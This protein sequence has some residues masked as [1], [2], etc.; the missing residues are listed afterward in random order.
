MLNCEEFINKYYPNANNA[1]IMDA[2]RFLNRVD[3][4][5]GEIAPQR[6]L[7][8]KNAV[9]QLFYLQ[10]LTFISRTNYQKIKDYVINLFDWLGING[11]VPTQREVIDAGECVSY[12]R[13]LPEALSFIDAV[14]QYWLPNYHPLE[15]LIVVKSIYILGWYGLT[16]NEI[17]D[18]KKEDISRQSDGSG[19][20][21]IGE[22]Q[23]CIDSDAFVFI[24]ALKT[25]ESYQ[26]LP[27]GRIR[28]LRGDG[29][30]LFR[31]ASYEESE[32]EA[33]HLV[34]ILK[35]FNAH[36][37]SH[38]AQRLAFRTIR[39]N[40]LF[41]EIQNDESDEPLLDKV[42]RITHCSPKQAYSYRT[43]YLAWIGMIENNII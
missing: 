26:S 3:E 5:C 28:H 2:K 42:L 34:Q 36:V 9:C 25:L 21:K 8:D 18:L 24:S 10:Q 38:L 4:V 32:I 40:A 14:G 15:D 13:G 37:P 7:Q 6:R 23:I 30:N 20:V 12:F 17:A 35:R 27:N 11:E 41:V 39:V 19:L 33:T 22:R 1:R 31:V 43:Q 16:L 29:N